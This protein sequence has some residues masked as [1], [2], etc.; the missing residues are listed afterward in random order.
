MTGGFYDPRRSRMEAQR[1][2]TTLV[3]QMEKD[4]GALDRV[5]KRLEDILFTV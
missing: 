3:A 4:Q 2:K 1:S 5:V